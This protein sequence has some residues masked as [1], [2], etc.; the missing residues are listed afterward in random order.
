[1]ELAAFVATEQQYRLGGARTQMV[2]PSGRTLKVKTFTRGHPSLFTRIEVDKGRRSWEVH[3]NLAVRGAYGDGIFCVDIGVARSGAVPQQKP[4]KGD[5]WVAC[6]NRDLITLAEVKKLAIYPM[7]LAQFVGIVHE[8]LPL[9]LAGSR[10]PG[11]RSSGHFEPSLL[12]LGGFSGNSTAVM[13]S[14][15]E[16]RFGVRVIPAFDVR[17]GRIRAG[18]NELPFDPKNELPVKGTK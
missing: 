6:L 7:L 9:Y 13:E 10:P 3:M 2:H 11:F 16:R 14:F 17:L 18:S 5:K 4:K 15:R 1:M 8:L 12:T